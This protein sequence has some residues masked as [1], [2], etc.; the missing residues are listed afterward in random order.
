MSGK[1][2][3][4]CPACQKSFLVHNQT[5]YCLHVVM[6]NCLLLCFYS[7]LSNRSPTAVV[8][9]CLELHHEISEHKRQGMNAQM[10][11]GVYDQHED[12]RRVAFSMSHDISLGE[13]RHGL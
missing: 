2:N 12:A 13:S 11:M 4:S 7:A 8:W 1:M 3:W 5:G 10:M 6:G 9:L